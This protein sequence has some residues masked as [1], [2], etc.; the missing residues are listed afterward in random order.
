MEQLAKGHG[1]ISIIKD[2]K[3]VLVWTSCELPVLA[4]MVHLLGA[5]GLMEDQ[6]RSLPISIIMWIQY[7]FSGGASGGTSIGREEN[8]K[9]TCST[10][11][12]T[13]VSHSPGILYL[14]SLGLIASSKTSFRPLSDAAL[15]F[16]HTISALFR[17]WADLG[18]CS[19]KGRVVLDCVL[20]H[21]SYSSQWRKICRKK[22]SFLETWRTRPYP[23]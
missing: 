16:S 17:C 23:C 9:L 2:V 1:E 15:H 6:Q 4:S 19:R 12:Q 3:D 13:K 8:L 5:E 11:K 18:L 7:A 14:H 21:C 20:I 22:R 10:V